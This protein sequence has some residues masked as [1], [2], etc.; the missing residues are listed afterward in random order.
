[1]NLRTLERDCSCVVL[2][3]RRDATAYPTRES[4]VG[5]EIKR[6][7]KIHLHEALHVINIFYVVMAGAQLGHSARPRQ[8]I[9]ILST[10]TPGKCQNRRS[11]EGK[12]RCLLENRREIQASLMQISVI[13]PKEIESW[14]YAI[15]SDYSPSHGLVSIIEDDTRKKCVT[16]V[17]NHRD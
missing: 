17:L 9:N 6:W 10:K 8:R 1:V 5:V 3:F 11:R 13:C 12:C 15:H 14:K 16:R 7:W 4:E 2:R